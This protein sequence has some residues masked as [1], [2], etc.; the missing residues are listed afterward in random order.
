MRS[1]TVPLVYRQ[2]HH[3]HNAVTDHSG[4]VVAALAGFSGDRGAPIAAVAAEGFRCAVH[5]Q[6]QE[7]C[8]G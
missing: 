8:F 1:V 5:Q 4:R 3:H 6:I 2:R 7:L